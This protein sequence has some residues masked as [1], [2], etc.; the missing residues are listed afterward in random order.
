MTQSSAIYLILN[1]KGAGSEEVRAAVM[2]AREAGHDIHVR[3]TWEGGDA[4]R[5]VDE[6][7]AAQAQ[8]IVA[9]GGDGTINEV[10]AA[11][12]NHPKA[13]RPQLGVLPL[14]T[15]NDFAK[16]CGIPLEA[17]A[18][19]NL[20]LMGEA[21]EIDACRVN[22]RAF[23][24]MATGGFGAQVTVETPT[25]QKSLLGG[26][27][28]LLTGLSK[29]GSIQADHGKVTSD[30]FEWE[31]HYLILAVGNGSQAGGGRQLCPEAVIN[32]GLLELRMMTG[33]EVLPALM[34]RLMEGDAADCI[35]S[36]RLPWFELETRTEVSINLDGEPYT[37]TRF[38]F[39][40]EPKALACFIPKDSPLLA[41][42]KSQ[43]TDVTG[44]L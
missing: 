38:R 2:A 28:Y 23:L 35:I 21:V 39:E 10:G 25:E 16:G 4:A 42:N 14:G 31:G 24:N 18:A 3:A 37:G 1:G 40:V 30:D 8:V 34:S 12:L 32:N 41:E 20:V 36:K 19:L 13:S 29:M 44:Y 9:G 5:Y 7:V 27:A 11:M 43:G 6:A 33:E 22:E 17:E 26:F 15:A